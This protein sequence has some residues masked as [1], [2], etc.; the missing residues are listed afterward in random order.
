MAWLVLGIAVVTEI[1][2]ALSLKWAAMRGSWIASTV[3]ISLSFLNMGLLALAM[4]G[5]PA[6]T[7]YAVWTGLGAVGVVICGAVFLGE[8]VNGMQGV[9]MVLTIAGV[10]GTKYF[11]QA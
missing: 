11:A 1:V 7:A 2:W 9:F 6:G 10:I 4:R 5:L 8:K 3:P